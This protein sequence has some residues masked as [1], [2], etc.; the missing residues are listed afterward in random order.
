MQITLEELALAASINT[1]V[2]LLTASLAE[3]NNFLSLSAYVEDDGYIDLAKLANKFL[4]TPDDTSALTPLNHYDR[5][6]Q[7][8]LGE[9]YKPLTLA[10]V[11]VPPNFTI[12]DVAISTTQMR[13]LLATNNEQQLE[14]FSKN[15]DT[16]NIGNAFA[17]F[18]EDG[19]SILNEAA[20]AKK[21]EF[22]EFLKT[23]S[24]QDVEKNPIEVAK[25]I[26]FVFN[27]SCKPLL[28]NVPDI[29]EQ[30]DVYEI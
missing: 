10:N 13:D 28:V 12:A 5:M 6:V 27:E 16:P 22:L 24:P 9:G 23:I 30:E 17:I 14:L 7:Q 29:P 26:L 1:D 3:N 15:P 11:Q 19:T 2:A 21:F 18:K 25:K 20:I 4:D 8:Y